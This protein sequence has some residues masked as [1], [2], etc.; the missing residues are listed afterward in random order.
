M[1]G[2]STELDLLLAEHNHTRDELD[3]WLDM[4]SVPVPTG[5]KG[6]VWMEMINLRVNEL[7]E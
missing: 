6:D 7:E 2:E 4:D 3:W 5:S 1:L